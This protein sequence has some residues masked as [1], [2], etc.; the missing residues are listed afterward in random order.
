MNESVTQYWGNVV[1]YWNKYNRTQKWLITGTA[2]LIVLTLSLIVFYF[3]KT[4]YSVAYTDLSPADAA[5]VTEYLETE[6]IPYEFSN[7]GQSIGVPSQRVTDVKI[8]VAAQNIVQDG[9]IGY[10]IFRDNMSSLG[11]TENEFGVLHTDAWAGEIEQLIKRIGGVRSAKVLLSLPEESV[12]IRSDEQ[13][14]A[15]ASVIVQ[16]D[17]SA[18]L[19]QQKIDTM[20]QL[21][22]RSVSDLPMENITISTDEAELLPTFRLNEGDGSAQNI[23]NQQ[24][25]IKRQYERDIQQN[26]ESFLGK[27]LGSDKVV[28]SVVAALNFD[29]ENREEKLFR[30]VIDEQGIERSVQEIQRSYSAGSEGAAG[31]VVG[32]GN[33]DIPNYPAVDEAEGGSS[34]EMERIVNYEIDEITRSIVSSPY[35]VQDLTIFAGIEPPNPNEPATLTD[36]TRA[37]VQRM[38]VNIVS[39]SLAGSDRQFSAEELQG[40]VAVITQMFDRA[41]TSLSADGT[42]AS[43]PLW[44]YILIGAA[45]VALVGGGVYYVVRRNNKQ[46]EMIVE[47]EELD[48]PIE[49]L[50]TIDLEA[51]EN[52]VRKQLETLARQ[53]PDEFVNLLRSWLAEE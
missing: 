27:I 45:A 31:G 21:V 10:G 44:L 50:Q 33:A 8:N 13:K 2:L 29:Q 5:A 3:S 7:D 28:V 24:L 6:G 46:E 12:F 22:H 9:S 37:E 48:V 16:F 35:R 25:E 47:Q 39:A 53:K 1:Q 19:D 42:L 51:N 41:G 20:Y 23:V 38:L 43:N 14:E 32:T 15:S 18:R 17:Q 4:E 52:Q 30:P 49:E 40:K 26:V 34:E 11:M 36:D